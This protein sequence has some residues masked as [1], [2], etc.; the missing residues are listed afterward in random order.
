[1]LVQVSILCKYIQSDIT[2]SLMDLTGCSAGMIVSM[3]TIIV[4]L[5]QNLWWMAYQQSSGSYCALDALGVHSWC[6]LPPLWHL[7]TQVHL[8][9]KACNVAN[10]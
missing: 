5:Y 3:Y 4:Y 9:A 7:I 1:M 8:A 6:S 2:T 10:M